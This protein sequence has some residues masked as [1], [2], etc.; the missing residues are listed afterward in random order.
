MKNPALTMLAVAVAWGAWAS[1]EFVI[2][3]EDFGRT[4]WMGWVDTT[5]AKEKGFWKVGIPLPNRAAA[6]AGFVSATGAEFWQNT[7]RCAP[8]EETP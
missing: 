3:H 5:V 7:H 6:L 8:K 1:Q 2:V 4:H